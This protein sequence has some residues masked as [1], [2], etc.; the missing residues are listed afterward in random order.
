MREN[1]RMSGLK[2]VESNVPTEEQTTIRVRKD[3][4]ELLRIIAALEGKTIFSV[5]DKVLG[6]FIRRYEAA[7]GRP[8]QP[9]SSARKTAR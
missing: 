4:Q 3:V 5:T 2:V 1:Q 9:R 6:D 8:L 7:S